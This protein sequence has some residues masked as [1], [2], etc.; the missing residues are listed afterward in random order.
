MTGHGWSLQDAQYSH[1]KAAGSG[2]RFRTRYADSVRAEGN[3]VKDC[4]V[5]MHENL[6]P[7][8]QIYRFVRLRRYRLNATLD[9]PLAPRIHLLWFPPER[10]P[11]V[12]ATPSTTRRNAVA[13][14]KADLVFEMAF[15]NEKVKAAAIHKKMADTRPKPL[16]PSSLLQIQ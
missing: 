5:F 7:Q 14:R 6:V 10:S 16:S 1:S 13:S 4:R 15:I 11:E 9:V 3:S 2:L 12:I 8:F